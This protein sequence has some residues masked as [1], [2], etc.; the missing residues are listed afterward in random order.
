MYRF[1]G[2]WWWLLLL[3]LGS[4]W[5]VKNAGTDSLEP[6]AYLPILQTPNSD[7]AVPF[8]DTFT[9]E[10][11]YYFAT[12]AGNCL[13]EPS[14]NDLMV[15]ALN[16]ADYGNAEW[17]GGYIQVAGPN[18]F[19]LVRIV[20]RCADCPSGDVDLSLEAFAHIADPI[21]GRVPIRWQFVSTPQA[22]N[23]IYQFKDG[24]N[25]WWTAVQIRNH[26]NPIATVEYQN[27]QG[28]WV[29]APRTQYN[30]FLEAAGMGEGP[31]TFR[32]T[33]IFGNQIVTA[34]VPLVPNEE[35]IGNGQFPPP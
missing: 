30:Y 31:F 32:V 16:D 24:S 27:K 1:S 14:P 19:V 5:G 11:T 34:N 28:D 2:R 18:G 6:A 33:D 20:D 21:L 10:G 9:G 7:V 23:I 15:A 4:S 25:P 29:N 13:F 35:V 8:G 12:G 22:G 3:I 26:R 17:C